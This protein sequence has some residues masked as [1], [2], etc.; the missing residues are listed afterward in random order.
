VRRVLIAVVAAVILACG[1]IGVVGQM[2]RSAREAAQ[3]AAERAQIAAL[4]PLFADAHRIDLERRAGHVSHFALVP[5][6]RPPGLARL[7]AIG[8]PGDDGVTDTYA[9][10]ALRAIVKFTALPGA[11]PCGVQTCVR[12]SEVGASTPDAPSLEHVAIWLSGDGPEL[13]PIKKFWAETAWVPVADAPWF[14]D[15]A[16]RGDLGF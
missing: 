14:T 1:A 2:R 12:D 8:G 4:D 15:L 10:G 7:E 11:H 6:T 16:A 13:V 5:K 9:S 3:D